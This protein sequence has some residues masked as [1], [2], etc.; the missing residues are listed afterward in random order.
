MATDTVTSTDAQR[1]GMFEPA[2]LRLL[3]SGELTERVRRSR[4]HLENCDLCARYCRVDR[5]Q[6]IARRDLP[7]RRTSGR[8]FGW[9]A[10]WRRGLSA[11][12]ARLGHN[13]LLLVQPALH[14]LPELGDCL[15]G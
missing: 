8:L 2:Y 6:S 10:P 11:R 9:T 4:Q 1:R 14:F 7:D 15:A 3:R 12:L 13:L 5:R